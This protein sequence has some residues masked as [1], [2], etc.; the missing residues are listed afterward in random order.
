M[1]ARAAFLPRV[2]N[3]KFSSNDFEST[4]VIS[5]FYVDRSVFIT[6]ATGFM[7]KVLIEKLLRSCPGIDKL[8]LLMRPKR[9]QNPKDRLTELTT[10]KVSIYE[11]IGLHHQ[12][13]RPQIDHF[14]LQLFDQLKKDDPDCFNK[15]VVIPGDIM[16][17]EMG[18]SEP[19]AAMLI[20]DVS[21]V[22]HAAATVKFDE[23]LKVS[24]NMNVQGTQRLVA[25]CQK[26]SKLAAFVH[27]STAYC[28][29][30]RDEI[31]EI[32]YP[33]PHDPKQIVDAMTWMADDFVNEITPK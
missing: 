18:I 3:L 25:L 19:D 16:E 15:L 26:M 14:L 11:N 21:I 20:D 28:N 17:P 33:P 9:G 13:I 29:C 5:S 30:D 6:G 23:V 12:I 27:V 10:A 24:V 31:L 8:Y 2:S 32:V 4:S 22:F 7:G 1:E